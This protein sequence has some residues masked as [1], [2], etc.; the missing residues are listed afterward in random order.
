MSEVVT[1][2]AVVLELPVASF[3]SRLLA[4]TLDLAFQLPLFVAIALATSA[5]ANVVNDD[6]LAALW[7]GAYLL[8]MV[9]YP[10]IFETLTRGKTLGKMA[11]GLRVVGDDGSPERFRQAL[12]RSLIGLIEIYSLTPVALIASIV[13][14]KGKRL[15][16][17]FAGTYALQERMPA[18]PALPPLFAMVP[19]PL[20]GW[21]QSL[22]LSALSD[23]TADAASSYLR[24]FAE[25]APQAREALGIQLANAVAAEVSP[26]PPPGT[27]PAAYLAAVLAVR[28][29]RDQAR[30]MANV[31]APLPP[32]AQSWGTPTPPASPPPVSPP[33]VSLPTGSLPPATPAQAPQPPALQPPGTLPYASPSPATV[34]HASPSP[35]ADA[36][37][38][39][40]P[41]SS[42]PGF[43]PP[44]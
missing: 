33:P 28:R 24:R 1:G 20:M 37:S 10:T 41:G 3:P 11:L 42:A 38:A 19:P 39:Q 7:I 35:D 14:A 43:A 13:S 16:D 29:E 44:G 30:A 12:V 25:L 23:Q 22:Q 5:L 18:R 36:A 9:G 4:L 40:P 21:A 27:P 17:V 34:P 2:E 15:G 8:V 32:A 6:Y 26:P 31:T